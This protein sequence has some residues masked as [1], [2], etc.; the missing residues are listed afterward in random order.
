MDTAALAQTSIG[1]VSYRLLG[2]GSRKLLF[3][4]GFPG[5]SSQ[6]SLFNSNFKNLDLQVLCFDRPGYNQTDIKS[7]DSLKDT[8]QISKELMQQLQWPQAEVIALSG[9]TPYGIALALQYPQLI[10]AVRVVC[11]LGYLRNPQI[12]KY[13]SFFSLTSMHLLPFVPGRLLQKIIVPTKRTQSKKRSQ[14]FEFFYPTSKSDQETI[15]ARNLGENLDFA[16]VEAMNLLGRG[17]K[18]DTKAFFSNWGQEI[19]QLKVPIHFWHGDED[20][21]ISMNVS[22]I[23]SKLIPHAHFTAVPGEGHISL[24]TRKLGEILAQPL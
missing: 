10:K 20:L 22:I 18:L 17:P 1:P 11:G 23:M 7:K 16:L 13:F 4:H 19:D 15:Q 3:F 9:G 21:V 12:K 8:I 6:I 14:V 2:T 24:P 5:S